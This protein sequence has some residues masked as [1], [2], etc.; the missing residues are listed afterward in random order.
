[1]TDVILSAEEHCQD[2]YGLPFFVN[3]KPVD[4]AMD[5]KMPQSRQNIVVTLAS[6]R[7]GQK[8]IDV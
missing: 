4:C 7:S 2:A 3:I 1:M 5:R 6:V 8:A